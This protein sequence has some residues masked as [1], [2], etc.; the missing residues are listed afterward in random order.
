MG[1]DDAVGRLQEVG[2]LIC[3]AIRLRLAA[4]TARLN[5]VVCISGSGGLTKSGTGT[6]TLSGVNTYSGS[7][8]VSDGTLAIA[9]DLNSLTP[10]SV[11]SP[12]TFTVQSGGVDRWVPFG[13]RCC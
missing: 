8:S 9:G 10:L 2:R 6:L 12:G 3:Q 5:S 4:M 13:R 1:A 11:A 7:T